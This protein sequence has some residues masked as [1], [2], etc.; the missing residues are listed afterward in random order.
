MGGAG[1]STG[2]GTE[3]SVCTGAGQT[4]GGVTGGGVGG[5][6]IVALSSL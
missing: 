4:T 3:I 5:S 2:E 6:V 1:E